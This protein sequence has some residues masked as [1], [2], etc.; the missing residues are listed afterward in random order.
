MSKSRLINC[1][2][3]FRSYAILYPTLST[4]DVVHNNSIY[5]CHLYVSFCHIFISSRIPWRI[6]ASFRQILLDSIGYYHHFHLGQKCPIECCD[7]LVVL[8]SPNRARKPIPHEMPVG[9]LSLRTRPWNSNKSGRSPN[10]WN[11]FCIRKSKVY[12]RQRLRE[13]AAT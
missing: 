11:A 3:Y 13:I 4:K 6:F 2:T 10:R 9:A 5:S 7:A 12:S 8:M 1:Q